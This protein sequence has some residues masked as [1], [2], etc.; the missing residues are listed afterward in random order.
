MAF[1][2]PQEREEVD[3]RDYCWVVRDASP[4]VHLADGSGL[5]LD[6]GDVDASYLSYFLLWMCCRGAIS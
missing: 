3:A 4:R 5:V 2:F 6:E 1:S